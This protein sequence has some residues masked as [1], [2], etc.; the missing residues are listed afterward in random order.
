MTLNLH[1]ASF[2]QFLAT[3]V[4]FHHHSGML[5]CMCWLWLVLAVL[6][7]RSWNK[8]CNY[9]HRGTKRKRL[10]V[11]RYMV[12]MVNVFTTLL[13]WC[14]NFSLS[15]VVSRAFSALCV[16]SKLGH[17]SQPQATFV[18]NFV[19]FAT[20]TAELAHE[21]KLHTQSITHPAY[22]MSWKLNFGKM[23]KILCSFYTM[24]WLLLVIKPQS[25]CITAPE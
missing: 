6:D 12:P 5:C 9:H 24:F 13:L 23:Y 1:K 3:S 20:S 10:F 14:E 4:N 16:Y 21:E 11:C 25:H 19:S 18:S 2:S 17:H 22:L 15:S 8:Q 7:R